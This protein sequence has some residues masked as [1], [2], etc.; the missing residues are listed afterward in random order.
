MCVCG[1][2]GPMFCAMSDDLAAV[3]T[4]RRQLQR[5]SLC[6]VIGYSTMDQLPSL[7][8]DPWHTVC[9]RS[10]RH[11]LELCDAVGHPRGDL[12]RT[13]VT[14]GPLTRIPR[15]RRRT[16]V[17][18]LPR[19][20]D[21]FG[22]RLQDMGSMDTSAERP[23]VGHCR[24]GGADA[25]RAPETRAKMA[26]GEMACGRDGDGHQDAGSTGCGHGACGEQCSDSSC[27]LSF[28]PDVGGGASRTFQLELVGCSQE[29]GR[30]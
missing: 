16:R 25:G 2:G 15:A 4:L 30:Q 14:P 22:G 1:A 23:R 12:F 6:R 20:R 7:S 19:L 8:V 26:T 17:A 24:G 5:P 13:S 29:V 11:V 9:L 27:S 21:R 18:E 3:A 10:E 28:R